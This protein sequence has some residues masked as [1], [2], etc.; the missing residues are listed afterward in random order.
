MISN[1]VGHH[2]NALNKVYTIAARA[3]LSVHRTT[4]TQAL[5]REA[6]LNPVEIF[7]DNIARRAAVRTRRL[8]DLYPLYCRSLRLSLSQT[9]S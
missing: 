6:G 9:L 2:M 3:I 8:D 5:L 4:P 7:L 1:R